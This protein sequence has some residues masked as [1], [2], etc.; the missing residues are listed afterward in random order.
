MTTATPTTDSTSAPAPATA[1]PAAAPAAREA[2]AA[3]HL[4]KVSKRYGEGVAAVD[5]VVEVDLAIEP[6]ELAVILGPSGSGKTTL[7]NLIGGI[8]G[9]TSGTVTVAG[10][11]LA[12][13][14]DKARTAYRRDVLGF[15]F[16]FYNLVPTLT[17]RENVA[18]ILELTGRH[19]VDQHAL[20]ALDAVGL[21]KRLDR[22]PSQLSGGEQQRVAI[23]RAIAKQPSLL[24]CDEP[25]GALDLETGRVVLALL[26]RLNQ[27]VGRTV[28]IV[29]H[30]IAIAEMAD[31]VV[32]MRSGQVVEVVHNRSPIAPEEVTW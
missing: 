17:A 18:L 12:D 28:V 9:P 16:Q 4:A 20:Q 30:N 19:D 27:E 23:A 22:F 21:G 31:R 3:V 24:L 13:L 26:R 2:G 11:D 1:A 6:G 10:R 32:R 25:T 7:L 15:V 5:A 14:D 29:T 8:E